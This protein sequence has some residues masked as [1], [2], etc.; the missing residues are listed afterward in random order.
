MDGVRGIALLEPIWKVI[1]T[2]IKERITDAVN[3]D[4]ALHGFRSERGTTTVIIEAKLQ[5]DTMMA[6]GK[7]M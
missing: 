3:F 2:I 1:S 6:T 7:T 4:H 5:M